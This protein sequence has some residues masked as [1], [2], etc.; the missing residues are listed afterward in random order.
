[1]TLKCGYKALLLT[2]QNCPNIILRTNLSLSYLWSTHQKSI[3]E[4]WLCQSNHIPT[5]LRC[6]GLFTQYDCDCDFYRNK[7]VGTMGLNVLFTWCDWYNGTESQ[8]LWINCSWNH[9]VWTAL[10]TYL[11]NNLYMN[12]LK[13]C[14]CLYTGMIYGRNWGQTI[15]RT[16]VLDPDSVFRMEIC[17]WHT[18]G[19]EIICD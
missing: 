5:V 15:R 1:M 2:S 12:R 6:K 3:T 14:H 19:V 10:E 4:D 9:S 8:L 18:F 17:R 7:W 13:D 16:R 11:I